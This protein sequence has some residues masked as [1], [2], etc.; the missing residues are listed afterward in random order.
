MKCIWYRIPEETES[1]RQKHNLRRELYLTNDIGDVELED[2]VDWCESVLVVEVGEDGREE[3]QRRKFGK[4]RES[5]RD[6]VEG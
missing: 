6:F 5:N 1:G 4:G 2:V 3:G